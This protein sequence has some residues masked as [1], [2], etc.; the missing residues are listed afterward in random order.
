MLGRSIAN[1]APV[2]AA[3]RPFE[4]RCAVSTSIPKRNRAKIALCHAK[5]GEADLQLVRKEGRHWTT[6]KLTS[7]LLETCY[8]HRTSFSICKL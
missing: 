8:M 4:R 3:Q 2:L 6:A 1:Q 7:D 5:E